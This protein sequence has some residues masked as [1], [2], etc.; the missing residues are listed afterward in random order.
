VRCWKGTYS[1]PHQPLAS[2]L[3]HSQLA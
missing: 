3:A 1:P 2:N